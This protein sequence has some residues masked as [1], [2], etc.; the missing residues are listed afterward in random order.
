MRSARLDSHYQSK[1]FWSEAIV[2]T[3]SNNSLNKAHATW[4]EY[5]LV[6]RA[7]EAK[8]SNLEWTPGVRQANKTL[9]AVR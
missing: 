9:K 8:Q 3:T 6:N 2:F 7:A 1:D 5:A 4:L